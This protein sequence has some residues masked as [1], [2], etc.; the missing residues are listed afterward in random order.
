M[1]LSLSLSL[2]LYLSVS[3]SHTHYAHLFPQELARLLQDQEHKRGGQIDRD[4]LKAIEA[5]DEELAI[6]MQEQEKL[7]LQKRQEKILAR[8]QMSQPNV[9]IQVHPDLKCHPA[10]VVAVVDGTLL[11]LSITRR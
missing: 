10:T 11:L 5:Q 1:S 8:R 4:K 2:S 6:V 9:R 7:R 3:V